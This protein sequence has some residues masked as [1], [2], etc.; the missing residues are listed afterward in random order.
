MGEPVSVR[1]LRNHGGAVLDTVAGGGVV[2]I[3]RDGVAVAELRP[4]ARP[5]LTARELIRRRSSLPHVDPRAL[6]ADLDELMDP[7][8]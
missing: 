1:E 4:L 5:A 2:V 8:L 6:R 3:R 7:T